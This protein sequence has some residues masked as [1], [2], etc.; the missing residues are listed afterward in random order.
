M[1]LRH[2]ALA[3]ILL[4][5][6]MVIAHVYSVGK[7]VSQEIGIYPDGRTVSVET[8]VRQY[9]SELSPVKEQYGGRFYVTDVYASGGLGRVR[10]EDGHHAYIADFTY[11]IRSDT[12][13]VINSFYLR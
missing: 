4:I 3:L 11:V 10:Y 6:F 5:L 13:I 2:L 8:Y 9:I 7:E 12:G 1:R